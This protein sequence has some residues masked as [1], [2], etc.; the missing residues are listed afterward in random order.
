MRLHNRGLSSSADSSCDH[1]Q[2]SQRMAAFH[3]SPIRRN[4]Q[5]P[6]IA[7]RP[8]KIRTRS[9]FRSLGRTEYT[10]SLAWDGNC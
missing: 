4:E 9:A 10:P 1:D 8:R 5:A 6:Q 2:C 7:P 3:D